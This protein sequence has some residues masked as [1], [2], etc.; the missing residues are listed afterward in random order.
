VVPSRD[1]R[2]GTGRHGC[3]STCRTSSSAPTTSTVSPMFAMTRRAGL[4]F[5]LNLVIVPIVV[6]TMALFVWLDYRHET[7]AIMAA[8]AMHVESA[9]TGLPIGPVPPGVGPR[10]VGRRAVQIHALH[11]VVTVVLL[12]LAVNAALSAYVLT[13]LAGAQAWI[14]RMER[15]QWRTRIDT[16]G[17]VDEVGRLVTS[18]QTLGLTIDALVFQLLNAERLATAAVLAKKMA[19]HIE[20]E[21]Q[22]LVAV[23][24]RLQCL[25]DPEAQ[26]A[27]EDIASAAARIVAATRSL[28]RLFDPHAKV[29]VGGRFDHART[30][31]SAR[32]AARRPGGPSI[33]SRGD[34]RTRL[35]SA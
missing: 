4:R 15:G 22:R 28:D 6:G 33:R 1:V 26:A 21:V 10:A 29:E 23:A 31:R 11:A 18:F 20:P 14:A 16:A 24:S 8:H 27:A 12:M 35:S 7:Q 3:C 9:G 25:P 34:S 19:G 32:A 13:P 17:D 5:K 2:A 30:E